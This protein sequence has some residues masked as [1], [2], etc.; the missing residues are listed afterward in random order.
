M[1]WHIPY[2]QL[3]LTGNDTDDTFLACALQAKS[4]IPGLFSNR[5]A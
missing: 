4:A 5:A 1:K 2:S 3:Q